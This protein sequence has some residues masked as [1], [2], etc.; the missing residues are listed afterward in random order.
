[1]VLA[2]QETSTVQEEVI[3]IR[4]AA[5]DI[6]TCPQWKFLSPDCFQIGDRPPESITTTQLSLMLT[7]HTPGP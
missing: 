7:D 2:L 5:L 6:S 3:L 1:M 4:T